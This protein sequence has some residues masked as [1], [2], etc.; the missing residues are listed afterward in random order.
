MNE[1][2]NKM[3]CARWAYLVVLGALV[4]P[5]GYLAMS[6]YTTFLLPSTGRPSASAVSQLGSQPA[7]ATNPG[8][9]AEGNST[10]S[11]THPSTLD[12]TQSPV[13]PA[14]QPGQ[15]APS[16]P[17]PTV[18]LPTPDLWTGNTRVNILLLGVDSADW[19]SAD[20]AGPPRADTLILLS[21]DPLSKS[22]AML[23]IPRDMWVE[24][25]GMVRPN[26]IN[27]T[28]RFG[29]L[30][31]LP[32]GG[33]GLA[34]RTVEQI[35][36][37]PIHYYIRV[38]FRAFERFIDE[39][40]GVEV[41]VPYSIK[42]DPTGPQNTVVLKPGKRLL[43]GPIALGYAR[44][45]STAGGDF[46]RAKRQ[47]QVILAVR[48]RILD[49]DMLPH[50]V[51]K[52][53]DLYKALSAGVQSNITI[54]R[55]IK[56][57]WLA[58]DVRFEDIRSAVISPK[59]MIPGKTEGGDP[60]YL[61]NPDR[62]RLLINDL[63]SSG[64]ASD[65]TPTL[66]ER[67]QNEDSRV[68]IIDASRVEGLAERTAEKFRA[69]GIVVAGITQAEKITAKTQLVDNTGKAYTVK[70]LA[71]FLGVQLADIRPEY[72]PGSEVDVTVILG[73]EWAWNRNSK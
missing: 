31:R 24:I 60:V 48:N 58:R 65:S 1:K 28:H 30:Y 8:A 42:V 11:T 12:V 68:T 61:P 70:Y 46:D 33:P 73:Y 20:R 16:T 26:K 36:N 54:G 47:Q 38:D 23:S 53:P 29:E 64:S 49:L 56:L 21:I 57:A 9:G 69:Q 43:D 17:T 40:D 19:E 41:D 39:I 67:M 27:T 7:Q 6:L 44:N 25:P 22:A 37:I 50:L 71:Q 52:A 3:G 2:Q 35:L 14:T 55:A 59:E 34:M 72:T 4:I 10:L 45:R 18:P 15:P 66:E 5:L 63:F 13:G 51:A 32:G 62:I